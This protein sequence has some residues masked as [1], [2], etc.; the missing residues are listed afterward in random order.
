[1]HLIKITYTLFSG[2][3]EHYTH[4]VVT[5]TTL[6]QIRQIAAKHTHAYWN[7]THLGSIEPL[8]QWLKHEITAI[9]RDVAADN[10]PE[11]EKK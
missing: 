3:I 4:C 5:H 2:E 8:P 6:S 7:I 10:E 11:Q 9:Q 1:M